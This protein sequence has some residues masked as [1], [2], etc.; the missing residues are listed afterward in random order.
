MYQ[1]LKISLT[2]AFA[3]L[4]MICLIIL[5]LYYVPTTINFPSVGLTCIMK[6]LCD[7]I[8]VNTSRNTLHLH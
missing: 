4:Y 1:T 6:A 5:L 3:S 2:S 7:N 8:H